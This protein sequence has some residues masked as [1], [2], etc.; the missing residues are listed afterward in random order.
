MGLVSQIPSIASVALT[1]IGASASFT[2]SR[3]LVVGH[4]K[5]GVAGSNSTKSSV[6]GLKRSQ[7]KNADVLRVAGG[8]RCRSI[9]APPSAAV[10]RRSH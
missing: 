3:C 2:L 8:A 9:S 4:Q 6:D 10:C 1:H 5:H 7:L